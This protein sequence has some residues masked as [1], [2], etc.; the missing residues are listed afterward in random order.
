MSEKSL[1]CRMNRRLVALLIGLGALLLVARF[2]LNRA[3]V[4]VLSGSNTEAIYSL[5]F[6][7][8]GRWLAAGCKDNQLLVWDFQAGREIWKGYNPGEI[9]SVAF[10][11]DGRLLAA[12]NT[13]WDTQNRTEIT[14]RWGTGDWLVLNPDGRSLATIDGDSVVHLWDL[15][16]GAKR[17]L[18]KG[19]MVVFSGDGRWLGCN[20]II[21]DATRAR[22]LRDLDPGDAVVAMNADGTLYL[23]SKS[24]V[25][26]VSTGRVRS[27]L[28]GLDVHDRSP[29]FSPDSRH[30]AAGVGHKVRLWNVTTGLGERTFGGHGDKVQAVAFSP[31]GRYLASGCGTSADMDFYPFHDNK[32]RIWRLR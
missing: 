12:N 23:G 24:T 14:G 6:S 17:R 22:K 7:R 32:I 10:S 31:D 20:G 26:E 29:V 11:N 30:F 2:L 9:T 18:S 16:T 4:R 8:D 5:A 13:L 19:G 25:R 27:V 15:S 28:R 3:S 1:G 21:W